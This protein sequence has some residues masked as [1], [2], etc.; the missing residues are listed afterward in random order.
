MNNYCHILA[1]SA[2]NGHTT[3]YQH[4][5]NVADI[6]AAIAPNIGLDADIARQGALLHD[7]G[8]ASSVF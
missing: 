6:A 5:K 8:K 1:K 3:L 7:I 4:L 2:A